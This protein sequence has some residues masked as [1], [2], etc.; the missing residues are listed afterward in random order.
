MIKLFTSEASLI[1]PPFSRVYNRVRQEES[2]SDGNFDAASA[3]SILDGSKQLNV[4]LSL[5]GEDRTSN[6]H[7]SPHHRIESTT[8]GV[9]AS[10]IIGIAVGALVFIVIGT[11]MTCR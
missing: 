4:E 11:R 5:E 1:F 3:A 10:T 2:S 6:R 9:D 7:N 8:P